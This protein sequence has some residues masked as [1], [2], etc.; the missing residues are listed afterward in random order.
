MS[1]SVYSI[2]NSVNGRT[3]Y[4]ATSGY[5]N[6][7]QS[8]SIDLK[9]GNH[10][11]KELQYDFNKYGFSVFETKIVKSFLNKPSAYD[12]EKGLIEDDPS[13]YNVVHTRKM[14][15]NKNEKRT[16]NSTKYTIS[17]TFLEFPFSQGAFIYRIEDGSGNPLFI[18]RACD[19]QTLVHRIN[20]TFHSA[21]RGQQLHGALHKCYRDCGTAI[22]GFVEFTTGLTHKEINQRMR[23]INEAA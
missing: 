21:S 6:R 15:T 9:V 1:Y 11:N 14:V 23:V 17:M 16:K 20:N 19:T 22:I 10:T 7:V 18:G 2:T 8:H 3:Y 4:G 13:C 5:G 12:Y